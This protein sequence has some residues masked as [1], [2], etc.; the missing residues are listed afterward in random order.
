MKRKQ[1]IEAWDARHCLC[2]GLSNT[3]ISAVDSLVLE[4]LFVDEE[5][6]L[7]ASSTNGHE[8]KI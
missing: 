7:P 1:L 5:E 3:L 4:W 6:P 2:N 8:E